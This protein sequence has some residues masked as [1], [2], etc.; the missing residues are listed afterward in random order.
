MVRRI[1]KIIREE[2]VAGQ[3]V[4]FFEIHVSFVLNEE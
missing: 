1:L 3:Q 4:Q 2:Y